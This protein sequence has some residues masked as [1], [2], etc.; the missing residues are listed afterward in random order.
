MLESILFTEQVQVL[1]G[2]HAISQGA[3][4]VNGAW[5]KADRHT[6]IV[7]LLDVGLIAVTG[8]LDFKLQQANTAG[9]GGVK[10]ITGKAITQLADTADNKWIAIEL[11]T[12]ELDQAGG[13][14]WVRF[15]ITPAVAA[16]LISVMLLGVDP[17][18]APVVQTN[19]T[20]V[21]V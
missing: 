10:D 17:K 12:S 19:W 3:G 5:I 2:I 20:Q 9:G 16:S 1:D 4:A 18:N 21:I 11:L 15:V 13:F 14:A 6:R 8:T 7:A